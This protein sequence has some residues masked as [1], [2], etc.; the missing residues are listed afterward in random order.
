MIE[1]YDKLQTES[2]FWKH[3]DGDNFI[4][5]LEKPHVEE[6]EYDGRTNYKTVCK[7]KVL[8]VDNGLEVQGVNKEF[9]EVTLPKAAV[10]LIMDN[11]KQG[12]IKDEFPMSVGIRITKS[13]SGKETTYTA[14]FARLEEHVS[15][16]AGTDIDYP[17]PEGDMPF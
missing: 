3:Q 14:K 13:G 5:V 15:K 2:K 11:F 16:I 4:Q 9:D 1:G 10:D 8:K 17:Q 6:Y 7:A 12:K